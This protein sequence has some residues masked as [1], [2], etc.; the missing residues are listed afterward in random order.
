MGR[1]NS[2]VIDVLVRHMPDYAIDSV[3]L[4][5]AGLDHA[6]Y[7]VNGELILRFSKAAKG[8]PEPW[9]YL[10]KPASSV[11]PGSCPRCHP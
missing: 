1:S 9:R 2:A 3:R 11:S 8:G 4:L 5:G 10:D 6:A 7:E